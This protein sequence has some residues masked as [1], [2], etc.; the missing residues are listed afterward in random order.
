ML[1][2]AL[3]LKEAAWLIPG[4]QPQLLVDI[5][6]LFETIADLGA[7]GE[8]MRAAFAV[9]VYRSW[10]ASRGDCRKSCSAIPIR[11]RTADT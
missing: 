10:W 3:L 1:E 2:V 7:S 9:P 4:P 8:I 6:P 11:T 5:V